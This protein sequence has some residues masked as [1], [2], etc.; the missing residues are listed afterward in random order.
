MS[1][2]LKQ[3][4]SAFF[5]DRDTMDEALEYAFAIAKASDNPMAVITAIM[6]VLNTSANVVDTAKENAHEQA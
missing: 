1:N 5:A 2:P 6:V 4:T 3:Y